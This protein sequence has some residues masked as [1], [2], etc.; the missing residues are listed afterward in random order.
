M[1]GLFSFGKDTLLAST[2]KNG[3]FLILEGK[4]HPWKINDTK[5]LSK[6]RIYCAAKIDD[7]NFV[8]GTSTNGLF[9][10]NKKGFIIRNIHQKVGLQ[11][12][13]V[14]CLFTDDDKN[15]W[16]GLDN[17]IDFVETS[18]PFTQRIIF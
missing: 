1:S 8:F 12:N 7:A 14:L 6:S 18:S 15:L 9:H 4:T 5:L 13:N 16:V 2:V 17:G 3:L 10:I 11:V